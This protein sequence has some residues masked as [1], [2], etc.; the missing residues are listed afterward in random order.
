MHVKEFLT[1]LK[2]WE[3]DD[4]G[5]RQNPLLPKYSKNEMRPTITKV[6]NN[7]LLFKFK[8][9]KYKNECFKKGRKIIWSILMQNYYLCAG[10]V[11][12][13]IS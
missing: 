5:E 3:I 10:I 9:F 4:S 6:R 11:N 12:E 13:L 7:F 2:Y 8:N 1:S